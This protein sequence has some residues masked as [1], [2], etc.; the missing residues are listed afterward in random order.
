MVWPLLTLSLLCAAVHSLTFLQPPAHHQRKLQ[1]DHHQR[2]RPFH[3][4][5]PHKPNYYERE[6]PA[7][8]HSPPWPSKVLGLYILLADDTE[9]G[10]TSEAEWTPRL[11]PWQQTASNVLFFTF[12]HPGTMEIPPAFQ[13]LAASRGDRQ[14]GRRAGRH[15]HHVCYRR[16]RLLT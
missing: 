15:R 4:N 13:R 7:L 5:N 14:T 16:L 6:T 1:L 9:E 2:D 12:I 10:F 11:R 3:Q 8:P